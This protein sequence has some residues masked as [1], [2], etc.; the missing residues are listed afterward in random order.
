MCVYIRVGVLY[1]FKLSHKSLN[2]D[3]LVVWRPPGLRERENHCSC[4]PSFLSLLGPALLGA[5]ITT[6]YSQPS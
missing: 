5:A 1:G 6:V 3:L 4:N 2:G